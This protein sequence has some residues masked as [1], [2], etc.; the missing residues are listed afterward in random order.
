MDLSAEARTAMAEL[1]ERFVAAGFPNPWSWPIP[2]ADVGDTSDELLRS[3]LLAH[4]ES[5]PGLRFTEAGRAWVLESRGLVVVFCLNMV[6]GL[7][8]PRGS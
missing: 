1:R 6:H 7:S 3:G 5:G 2:P 8:V 4:M